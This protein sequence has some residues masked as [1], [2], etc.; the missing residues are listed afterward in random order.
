[1]WIRGIGL[2]GVILYGIAGALTG[3][4]Q[5]RRGLGTDQIDCDYRVELLRDRVVA[6][7][8]RSPQ[9]SLRDPQDDVVSTLI[10]ET[11]TACADDDAQSARLQ[12]IGERL[13]EHQRLR[14]REAEARRELVAL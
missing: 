5:Q 1:M 13:R 3:L 9:H 14:A 4:A 2:I 10:R 8:E 7:T 12:L 6:L 11:Q